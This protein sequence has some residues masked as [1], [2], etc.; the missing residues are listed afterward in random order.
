MSWFQVVY[1]YLV[2]LLLVVNS[3]ATQGV[4]SW[5]NVIAACYFL[6]VGSIA[7]WIVARSYD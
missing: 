5:L 4:L 7:G 3:T 1:A 2:G 6:V